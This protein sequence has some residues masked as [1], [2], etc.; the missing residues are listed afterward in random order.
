M[1]AGTYH[2]TISDFGDIEFPVTTRDVTVGVG[3]SANVSF[4]A[5][6]ADT[7]GDDTGAF[8]FISEV[9][10][11]GDDEVYSGDVTVTA[12]VERGTARFEKL[13][14][15]VDGVDV[16][17]Q[18][19]GTPA[20]EPADEP[21]GGMDPEMA[22]AQQV[23][24]F[25]LGFNSANYVV[26]GD[27][28]DV[29]YMN[30]D[31]TLQVGLKVTGSETE[32]LSNRIEAEF[33]NDDGFHVTANL[34]QASHVADDGKRWYGG[35]AN[36][37]IV[38]SAL[39]VNYSGEEI[40]AVTVGLAGCE[41]E[42][43][44]NG[45]GNG[46]DHGHG[47]A[48]AS[49]EFDCDGEDAGRAITVDE[50][51]TDATIIN[52]DD[53]PEANIDMEGPAVA[54]YF[55]PNPNNRENGW[56]NLAVL[57]ATQA[58]EHHATNN[59]DGWL[60]YN[61]EGADDAGSGR[62]PACDQ[63]C[64]GRQWL[65]RRCDRGGA[66]CRPR[67]CL[68]SR[69]WTTTAWSSLPLTPSVTSPVCRM[70]T[71]AHATDGGY[72]RCRRRHRHRQQHQRRHGLRDVARGPRHRPTEWT[73]TPRPATTKADAIEAAQEA[74]AERGTPGRPR[75]HASGDRDRRGYADQRCSRSHL[76]LRRL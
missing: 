26:H 2:V 42:E 72:T 37:H 34:G 24:E 58:G 1:R 36:G 48:G 15:Y 12:S 28:T 55:V 56:V 50:G 64:Q 69:R 4:N 3:L 33:D 9:S 20:S 41:A 44:E 19:F 59:E 30:G 32:I 23:F 65:G 47:G 46:D 74:L 40:G 22:A 53:L 11:D 51:G 70:K 61:D 17:S 6:G 27:H 73:T 7:P 43:A 76:Q 49:F 68:G 57:L 52:E 75:Y 45:D 31:H 35:P 39:A 18:D 5:P 14:L 29:D 67:T 62:I 16:D 66:I 63:I 71:T 10:D 60:T 54:P 8:V 25:K 13:T 21:E 38:I